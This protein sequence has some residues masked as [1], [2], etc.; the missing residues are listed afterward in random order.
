M[1]AIKALIKKILRPLFYPFFTRLRAIVREEIISA[2]DSLPSQSNGVSEPTA[3]AKISEPK[4]I[5]EHE[6]SITEQLQTVCNELK[7]D[8]SLQLRDNMMLIKKEAIDFCFRHYNVNLVAELGC[9]L[10]VEG[11]YG[12]YIAEKHPHHLLER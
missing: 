2:V 12:R 6:R 5:N 4:L 8:I 1:T 11:A 7:D 3:E 10:N 9:V